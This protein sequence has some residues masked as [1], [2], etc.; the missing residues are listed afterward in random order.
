M[1]P[2]LASESIRISSLSLNGAPS[3]EPCTSTRPP[4][5]V[6]TKLASVSAVEIFGVIEVDHRLAPDDAAGDG[7]DMILERAVAQD[8]ALH[9]PFETV[10]QGDPGPGD[11]GRARAAVRLKHV[12]ID[13][14]LPLAE[15]RQVDHRAQRS[16]NQPLD[17]LRSPGHLA[18]RGF[19]SRSGRGGARQHRVFRRD[20]SLALA[21][22]P[23]RRLVLERSC[24]E[25]MGFAEP[26][27][28]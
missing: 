26:H 9:H 25:H 19:P 7:G 21:A 24:A 1:T 5:P 13:R 16:A 23:R 3:A 8:R 15:P 2:P 14:D 28:A 6:M 27:Q 4:P 18:G 20:P 17:F 10:M 22:Q 11:R 12:A